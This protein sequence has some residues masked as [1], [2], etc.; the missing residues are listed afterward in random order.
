[1]KFGYVPERFPAMNLTAKE[2]I[3]QIGKI[4][5]CISTSAVKYGSKL[6]SL[7]DGIVFCNDLVRLCIF[8]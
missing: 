8:V 6:L 7:I 5:H 4:S 1:M 2:Y 3:N